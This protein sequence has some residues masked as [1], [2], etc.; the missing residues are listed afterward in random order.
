MGSQKQTQTCKENTKTFRC[1]G[2]GRD[3]RQ[4]QWGGLIKQIVD[5][6][7]SDIWLPTVIQKKVGLDRTGVIYAVFE[8]HPIEKQHS[9]ETGAF[10]TTKHNL[11]MQA[12]C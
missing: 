4:E 2:P 5:S 1:S 9:H 8:C 12:W 7:T 6:A 3:V 10:T 11:M